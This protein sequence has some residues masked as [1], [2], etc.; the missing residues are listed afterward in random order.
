MESSA[1]SE[2]GEKIKKKERE[3]ERSPCSHSLSHPLTVF[4]SADISLHCPHD[5]NAWNQLSRSINNDRKGN[6]IIQ[7]Y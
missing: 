7:K 5:L 1:K 3:R 6:I 2:S 4:C